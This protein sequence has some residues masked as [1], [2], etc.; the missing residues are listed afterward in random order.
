MK[1]VLAILLFVGSIAGL[2][3]QNL[4]TAEK[5]WQLGRV[6][7]EDVS[8][9]GKNTLY[10]V[11]YYSVATNKGNTDVYI[12]ENASRSS[13]KI[14]AFEGHENNARFRPDGKK[15]GFLKDGLLH[16]MNLD[17]SDLIQVSALEMNGFLYSPKGNSIVFLQD[18]KYRKT[19]RENNPDLPL[20]NAKTIE[21]LNYRHWKSWDDQHDSNVFVVDYDN[22]QLVSNPINIVNE[23]FEAPVDPDD[24]IEQVAV[25]PDGFLIAYSCKKATGTAYA[26]STNTDIYVY[27]LRTKATKNVSQQNKGFDKSPQFSPDGNYLVWNSMERDGF[28]S[29]KNRITLLDLKTAATTDITAT[30][31]NFG[32]DPKWSTDSK[33]VYFIGPNDGT[34]QI[35]TYTLSSKKID[36]LTKGV[37]DYQLVI[38]T[39]TMLIASRVSMANPA[40]IYTVSNQGEA[41]QLTFTNAKLWD[42]LTKGSISKGW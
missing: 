25:S 23:A 41:T 18:V 26:L 33:K 20:V 17:G 5:L 39:S 8:P 36:L 19:A 15:V 7:L 27:D 11:T 13:K 21:S 24:G 40:E 2:T 30:F 12:V 38:P 35:Y 32:D 1:I 14:T 10:T 16:E 6:N 29:D 28:E 31:D 34:R 37:Y 4:L 9:D 42:A 3:A 22:G